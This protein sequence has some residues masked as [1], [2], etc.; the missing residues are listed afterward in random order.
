MLV[1]KCGH[2]SKNSLLTK[3]GRGRMID[4]KVD[5]ASKVD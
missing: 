1:M 2:N 4:N 5:W 3:I